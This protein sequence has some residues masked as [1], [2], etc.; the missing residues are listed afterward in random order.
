MQK[1]KE[2]THHKNG[3]ECKGRKLI[4]TSFIYEL[5][6]PYMTQLLLKPTALSQND[7]GY[8]LPCQPVAL[9]SHC[10]IPI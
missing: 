8:E 10:I 7:P 5:W 9:I 2:K 4:I 6:Q 1:I 3:Q